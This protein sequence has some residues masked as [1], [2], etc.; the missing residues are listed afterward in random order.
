MENSINP[1]RRAAFF[2]F[3]QTLIEVESGR[4]GIKWLQDNGMLSNAYLIK[5]WLADLSRRFRLI[6]EERMIRILM[7]FYRRK[8]LF[9]F[10]SRAEKFFQDYLKPHLAPRIV[11]RLVE[12]RANG[13]LTV[14]VSGSIR[15]WLEPAVKHLKI[16]R[17]VAT[18]LETGPDGLLTGRPDGL[19]CIGENKRILV[20]KLVDTERID[21]AESYAYGN[22]ESDIPLLEIVGYPHAVEPSPAL[23]VAARKG[24]WPVLT[25]R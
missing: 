14:L 7:T 11:A 16:D 8:R 9:E 10:S 19:I 2:D 20:S 5:V 23:A 1:S 17:L 18:D 6:S 15:Y 24:D 3:D 25:F 12:H 22:H 13:D 4:M 21:L